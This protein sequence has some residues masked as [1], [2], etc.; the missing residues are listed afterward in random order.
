MTKPKRKTNPANKVY[1]DKRNLRARYTLKVGDM[2]VNKRRLNKRGPHYQ[3]TVKKGGGHKVIFTGP[4]RRELRPDVKTHHTL[5]RETL[6]RVP[7]GTFLASNTAIK[8]YPNKGLKNR[9][10]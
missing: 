5:D 3:R 6:K 7:K 2:P 8:L 9:K 1:G 10:K 4:E